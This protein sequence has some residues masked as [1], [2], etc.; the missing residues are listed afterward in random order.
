MAITIDQFLHDLTERQ[1]LSEEEAHAVRRRMASPLAE[2]AAQ[3]AGPERMEPASL[4]A[5]PSTTLANPARLVLCD[6]VI[7]NKL[8]AD[9]SHLIFNAQRIRDK[10]PVTIHVL[11]PGQAMESSLP[12]PRLNGSATPPKD[13]PMRPQGIADVGRHGEMICI[14][15]E[16]LEGE[17]L[18]QVVSQNGPLPLELATETLLQTAR[19]LKRLEE[20]GLWIGEI[21]PD[22][23][24]LDEEG[25]IHLMG[26]HLARIPKTG[27]CQCGTESSVKRLHQSLGKLYAYLHSAQVGNADAS[28][29]MN[30][31]P[32]GAKASNALHRSAKLV[33][34][35]LWG[36]NAIA[37]Y[38]G[39]DDLVRDLEAMLRGQE[40]SQPEAQAKDSMPSE[41][42]AVV[43]AP[44]AREESTKP[45]GQQAL[46][47]IVGLAI[48]SAAI[49]TAL[50]L[51]ND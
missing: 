5:E 4:P 24:L 37:L 32:E 46:W 29:E 35:R 38:P 28:V 43:K 14:C 11:V 40:L 47:W 49:V 16:S 33:F 48:A 42:A 19:T 44:L 51:L 17:T 8:Q 10:S 27:Q 34:A 30:V 13:Q 7:Q 15:C 3:L 1:L 41:A 18:E 26:Q 22:V 39:W 2:C 36:Q 50:S 45:I 12:S 6:S 31:S 25:R 20:R 9:E 23:L 21:S